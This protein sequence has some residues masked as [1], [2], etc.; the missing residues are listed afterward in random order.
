MNLNIRHLNHPV[1]INVTSDKGN[2]PTLLSSHFQ[3]HAKES[4]SKE[5]NQ[6]TLDEQI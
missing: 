5:R 4:S 3:G 1:G 2:T 6:I